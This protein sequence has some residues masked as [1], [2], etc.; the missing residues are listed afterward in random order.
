M[1]IEPGI[2]KVDNQAKTSTTGQTLEPG[3]YKADAGTSS[4]TPIDSTPVTIKPSQI[5]NRPNLS[6][7]DS[8]DGVGTPMATHD[9]VSERPYWS[10]VWDGIANGLSLIHI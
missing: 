8:L 9:P 4:I 10:S 7:V 2:Y 1:P 3:V 5:D 6:N